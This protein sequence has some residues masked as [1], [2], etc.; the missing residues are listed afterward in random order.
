MLLDSPTAMRLPEDDLYQRLGVPPGAAIAEL[1]RAYRLLALRF[2]PDRAGDQSTLHFQRIAEAYRILADPGLRATYDRQRQNHL[3]RPRP[4]G[5]PARPANG[6]GEYSGPGG[7]ITWR[8]PGRPPL[9]RV[10]GSIEALV[11]RGAARRAP[12]GVLELVLTREEAQ[13]GGRAAIETPVSITC[14]TCS[15]VAAH[16]KV[17]CR[18]C[19]YDGRVVDQVAILVEIPPEVPDGAPY[20]FP[21]DPTGTLP[22]LRVRIRVS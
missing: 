12:D 7:H 15:G 3:P 17:W 18:R 11:A 20:L 14:P 6:Q 4:A 21:T 1:R 22:P 5:V 16:H 19:E 8:F 10:S 2:H 9:E 13:L